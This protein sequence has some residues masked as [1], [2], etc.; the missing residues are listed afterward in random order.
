MGSR[1]W[2]TFGGLSDLVCWVKSVGNGFITCWFFE[3]R[4]LEILE[5]TKQISLLSSDNVW[6][7]I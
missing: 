5:R 6:N 7:V 4:L 2:Y 3:I 1:I